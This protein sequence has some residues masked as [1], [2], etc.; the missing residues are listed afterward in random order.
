[1]NI[2]YA[3]EYIIVMFIMLMIIGTVV[4]V[5]VIMS[6]NFK[7][8]RKDYMWCCAGITSVALILSS[9]TVVKNVGVGEIVYTECSSIDIVKDI[10]S[11]KKSSIVLIEGV[12]EKRVDYSRTVNVSL[13]GGLIKT[14]GNSGQY[15]YITS[16]K[17]L[18]DKAPP[19]K[20]VIADTLYQKTYAALMENE[21]IKLLKTANTVN[22]VEETHNKK[23][24]TANYGWPCL[25]VIMG[26]LT[27]FILS[28]PRKSDNETGIVLIV[29]PE[30][31]ISTKTFSDRQMEV[32]EAKYR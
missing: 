31:I 20:T 23:A 25:I 28:L 16:N 15:A 22:K 11:I 12:G 8:E 21:E 19:S 4:S 13:L 24:K 6:G 30:N 3:W 2:T 10:D 18:L 29:Q 26:S 9:M 1:M 32:L 5:I 17:E 7:M 27:V 14:H